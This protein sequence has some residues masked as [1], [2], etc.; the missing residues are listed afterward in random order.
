MIAGEPPLQ[1]V[2]RNATGA[3]LDF[4]LD[5]RFRKQTQWLAAFL[6]SENLLVRIGCTCFPAKGAWQ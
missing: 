2:A 3:D 4:S 1:W 6:F 5:F